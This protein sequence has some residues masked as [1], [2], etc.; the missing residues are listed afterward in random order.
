MSDLDLFARARTTDPVTSHEAAARATVKLRASQLAVLRLFE[1]HQVAMT[2]PEM[3]EKYSR[4]TTMLP[5]RYPKQSTSGLRTRRKELCNAGL[6]E[7]VG[8][9]EKHQLWRVS[10][11]GRLYP[12]SS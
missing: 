4:F 11:T 8:R 2:D 12:F 10:D 9:D 7:A 1:A 3:I 5:D 6:I